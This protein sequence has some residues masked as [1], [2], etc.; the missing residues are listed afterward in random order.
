MD[1]D[2]ATKSS[3]FSLPA[4]AQV[5]KPAE[6]NGFRFSGRHTLLTPEKLAGMAAARK[7]SPSAPQDT[8][9]TISF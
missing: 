5:L 7:N 8:T 2:T 3:G 4:S 1:N 9:P 6:M